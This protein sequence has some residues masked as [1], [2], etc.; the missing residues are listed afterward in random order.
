[1]ARHE[2]DRELGERMRHYGYGRDFRRRPG[3]PGPR[4]YTGRAGFDTF[5]Y[6]ERYDREMY[7]GAYPTYGGYP[8]SR[9][10]GIH[11]GGYD[12]AFARRPFL[13][14]DAYR[15]HPSIAE[16]PRH[17]SGR[18]PDE[19]HGT[20]IGQPME[21]EEIVQSVR[22][23]LY[24]DHWIDPDRIQVDVEDGVVTLRGEVDDYM[25]ARYA[26]DDAW[27]S[28]GVRGVVNHLTVKMERA[29]GEESDPMV[30]T[31]R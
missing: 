30:Q 26:W 28:T 6:G 24:A 8:G 13:P 29:S 31:E 5:G 16:P 4:P 15:R 9:R 21:D 17:L 2:W 20:D 1:M 22:E 18:W 14:E 25:E 3:G 11:Y 27:E 12:E 19:P 10:P 23:S 7:G